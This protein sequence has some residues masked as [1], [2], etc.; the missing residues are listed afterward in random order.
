MEQ[1]WSPHVSI[2]AACQTE[3]YQILRQGEADA[4]A[5]TEASFRLCESGDLPNAFCCNAICCAHL[6]AAARSHTSI[7][8]SNTTAAVNE[9]FLLNNRK[10]VNK[11]LFNGGMCIPTF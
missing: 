3:A 2:A 5:R 8:G 11:Y 1:R 7:C 10:M 9:L 4:G 6:D